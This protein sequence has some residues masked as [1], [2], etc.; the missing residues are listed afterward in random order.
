MTLGHIGYQPNPFRWINDGWEALK[1][2]A[3]TAITHFSPAEEEGSGEPQA[4]GGWGVMAADIVARSDEIEAKFEI[5][6]MDKNDIRVSVRNGRIVVE[7]EKH[8]NEHFRNGD[9]M[10]TERAF[11]RFS[12]AVML[13]GAVEANGATASYADGVLT[14]KIPRVAQAED[15]A[16]IPVS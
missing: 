16:S 12:R 13:P 2:R 7:G 15:G 6:G 1:D 9:L 10:V 4:Q 11:G 8:V 5:P 3:H 14:V